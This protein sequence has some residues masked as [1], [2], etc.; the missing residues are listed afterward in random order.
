MTLIN[1]IEIDNIDYNKN[2][3]KEAILNNDKIE[4]KLHII[5]VISNPCQFARRYILA[6]QFIKRIENERDA[7]LYIVELA[8]KNQKHYITTKNNPKHLQL[9]TETAPIW[10]KENMINLGVKN[11]LPKD[12]KAFA[13]VDADL[14]FESTNWCL[15]TLKVLN[16]SKDIV[17]V[18]SHCTDMD[19]DEN[20]LNIFSSFGYQYS[21][22]RPYAHSNISSQRWHPGYAWAITRRAYE[23]IGGLYQESILGSGDHNMSMCL[24]G[25][26][27][28]SLNK[29]VSKGY[30]KSLND[31]EENMKHLRLGYIPGVIRHYFHG[32]K[33]DR[34]Y[35]ER[36]KILVEH[37]YDPKIHTTTNEFGLIIPT[38]E[39]PKELL[40]D[41]FK[42]FQERN[43]DNKS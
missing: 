15:D 11:L 27:N 38:K 19:Y 8:Y 3:I 43:E 6:K 41:I 28:I 33:K 21:K 34:K 20:V 4:D 25:K 39:C 16:G 12:W 32:N 36:W 22:K 24:I 29:D 35:S 9:Y 5:I 1:L 2:E 42:Y 18:F 13:W 40:N 23:K 17:Q 7:I 26:G 10:H 31:Y 14:E 37:K 30:R